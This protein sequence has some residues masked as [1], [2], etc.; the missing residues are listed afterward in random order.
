M[1]LE[2]P[3]TTETF[4]RNA[5]IL[6]GEIEK[7]VDDKKELIVRYGARLQ[8]FFIEFKK[9]YLKASQ[10]EKASLES[11]VQ[12]LI[13]A[14][15]TLGVDLNAAFE[16]HI[17]TLSK[18]FP[19]LEKPAY[20]VM[21]NELTDAEFKTHL[22]TLAGPELSPEQTQRLKQLALMKTLLLALSKETQKGGDTW[23]LWATRLFVNDTKITQTAATFRRAAE[24]HMATLSAEVMTHPEKS[25]AELAPNWIA[26]FANPPTLVSSVMPPV[27]FG[28][29]TSNANSIALERTVAEALRGLKAYDEASQVL[30]N[31]LAAPLKESS[32]LV[33]NEEISR[34]VTHIK[35]KV[36]AEPNY[37]ALVAEATNQGIPKDKILNYLDAIVSALAEPKLQEKAASKIDP[38]KL[39]SSLRPSYVLYEDMMNPKNNPLN[40]S[41]STRDLIIEELVINGAL[42]LTSAAA[43][44]GA[45][46]LAGRLAGSLG[47]ETLSFLRGNLRFARYLAEGS[48]SMERI[49]VVGRHF[50]AGIEITSEALV[51]EF[52][53]QGADFFKD[54]KT[55]HSILNDC[56]SWSL[57]ILWN[58]TSMGV[59]RKLT[60][61]AERLAPEVISRIS[62]KIRNAPLRKLAEEMMVKGHV[63]AGVELILSCIREG[64]YEGDTKQFRAEFGD[65]C[66]KSY[67]QSVGRAGTSVIESVLH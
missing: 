38:S 31:V 7:S 28:E 5:E 12:K 22:D 47:T 14:I 62:G 55:F 18:G 16:D 50:A 41:D 2:H 60:P 51:S 56:P 20:K 25:L 42:I 24:L 3:S 61:L 37:S 54:E 1:P 57:D 39:S 43:G 17:K 53:S 35:L 58:M 26:F 40:P 52:V 32:E 21:L 48:R 36:Y 59:A 65:Y 34:I 45:A 29:A 13:F 15:K 6:R 67:L 44:A 33:T 4:K 49:S 10:E 64:C 63:D 9:T 11:A 27:Q 19:P 46:T 66:Y 30:E 23:T 8:S